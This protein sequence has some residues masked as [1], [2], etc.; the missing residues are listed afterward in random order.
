MSVSPSARNTWLGRPDP[1][2]QAVLR[3][4]GIT[5]GCFDIAGATTTGE[6]WFSLLRDLVLVVPT[7]WLAFRAPQRSLWELVRDRGR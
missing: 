6:A 1:L 5:C 3:R 4:L 7:A 2:A